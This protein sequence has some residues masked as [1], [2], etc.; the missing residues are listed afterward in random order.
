MFRWLFV[1]IL[2]S[3]AGIAGVWMLAPRLGS[4]QLETKANNPAEQAEQPDHPVVEHPAPRP[5]QGNRGPLEVTVYRNNAPRDL[6]EPVI[7]PEGT[8]VIVMKQEVAS[9]KE[10]K[11]DFI[12]TEVREG[13]VVTK[14]K[15]L[16]DAE[17]GFLSLRIDE[18][19]VALPS[20]VRFHFKNDP[21]TW[22]RRIRN[23]EELPPKKVVFSYE[24][25]N[26][27]KLQI[28]DRVYRGQLLALINPAKSF[29]DVTI[30][31]AALNGKA[32]ERAL[33][34]NEKKVYEARYKNQVGMNRKTPGTIP[35]DMLEE[36]RLMRD[37]YA[38][39]EE[40][41]KREIEKA[42]R[43]LSAAVT[44]LKIHEIRAAIDGVV[45]EIYKN[46]Q[47][48]SVKANEAI[49]RIENPARL[50]VEAHL[51]LQEALKLKEGMTAIVEASRPESPSMVLSGH[52][53]AVTCVAVSKGKTNDPKSKPP[54]IVSGSEDETLRGW[55]SVNGD[56]LWAISQLHSPVRSVACSPPAA[57]ANLVCFGCADGRVRLYDLDK[58][59]QKPRETNER[60]R[61]PVHCIAFSPDGE[62]IATGG[63]DRVIRLWKTETGELLHT[64]AN[65]SGPV[66][67]VQFASAKR[68]VSAAKDNRLIV[69]D[70]EANKPPH[71]IGPRFEGRGGEVLSLGVSP[72]GKTVLFDQGKELRLLTLEDQQIAGILQNPSDSWNFSTMALFSPD[73][74]TILTSGSEAERL[75]LWR[76]PIT[77]KRG[78]ELRQFI[79]KGAATCG[80]FAPE[81]RSFAV[82]GTQDRQ[83]LV[84]S[85][86]SQVEIDSRLEAQI[87]LVE[88]YLDTHS[89]EVRVR[90]EL[91][92]PEWLVPGMRA[93]MVVLP[94]K[95]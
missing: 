13:E 44:D 74:K 68:L 31:V 11:I 49:L 65:H 48:D 78:S 41:K 17:I 93:T 27:R 88:K 23:R 71:E 34:E 30:K 92:S 62:V 79:W 61:G 12:G 18:N 91:D 36:T 14:D 72:D 40:V 2:L 37:K 58:T 4:A 46:H 82:T 43:E 75:Q 64:L 21:V 89:R 54:I 33:A 77:Q 86:P 1:S 90:A 56:K 67:S 6:T 70:V 85:M 73:G 80:A 76:T 94:Q 38:T 55:N 81:D 24:T 87:T 63:D 69:W 51:E 53:Q 28:G 60:H 26:V 57:K 84:W 83:V 19:D 8:L 9:E 39:E 32:E 66:T 42:Q 47:G 7:I 35:F 25:L 3:A 52:L 59:D 20:D 5:N 22:Y 10:G 15:Q 45:K 95:K 16:P 50:R 29:E